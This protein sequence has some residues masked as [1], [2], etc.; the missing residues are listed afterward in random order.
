M[1]R[2]LNAVVF[3]S[4]LFAAL[5][6]VAAAPQTSQPGQMTQARVWVQ[7]RG[8]SEAIPVDLHAANLERPLRVHMTNG[9][10]GDGDAV[11]IQARAVRQAWDYDVVAA[12]SSA[13][14]S[15]LNARGAAGWE[16]VGIVRT[17]NEATTILLKRPR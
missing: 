14:A 11:A 17:S 5:P 8:K 12:S 9:E 7:N 10:P 16:A 2:R 4:L 6:T 3:G 1:H 13:L 15:T